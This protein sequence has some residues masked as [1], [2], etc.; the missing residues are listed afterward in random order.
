M[1]KKIFVQMLIALGLAIGMAL[2][3]TAQRDAQPALAL[4]DP[5]L[6]ADP[7]DLDDLRAIVSADAPPST[8]VT[9]NAAM[10]VRFISQGSYT[11]T[12]PVETQALSTTVFVPGSAREPVSPTLQAVSLRLFNSRTRFVFQIDIQPD[13]LTSIANCRRAAELDVPSMS[14][15]NPVRFEE[16]LRSFLP[17][18]LGGGMASGLARADA[19]SD[20]VDTRVIFSPTTTYPFRSIAQLGSGCTGTLVGPRHLVTVAHC[21]NGFGTTNFNNFTVR[22]ARNAVSGPLAA[23]FGSSTILTQPVAG[24]EA[25][26]FT[27]TSWQTAAVDADP[28]ADD[29]GLIV[30][31]DR[32]GDITGWMGIGAFSANQLRDT[33]H[34]NRGYPICT[35]SRPDN[36]ISCQPSRLY[37]NKGNCNIDSFSDVDGSGW[38]RLF[39]HRCDTSGGHSGS[40]MYG[41]YDYANGTKNGP[42]VVGTHFFSLCDRGAPI[43]AC[44]AADDYPSIAH[45]HTPG[46][47]AVMTWLKEFLP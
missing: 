43:P 8:P 20:G 22:P 46:D 26:Y 44:A 2:P 37:G 41:Y 42:W 18:A 32:L 15:D 14:V 19:R 33:T 24:T 13:A 36:P 34:Y 38:N 12:A 4:P 47:M 1:S 35:G 3:T 40:A 5:C 21:I 28:R 9:L 27:Y 31:P 17:M 23:P 39:S 16:G 6:P 7:W 25:W 30:I 10:T 45:R 11:D 29:W